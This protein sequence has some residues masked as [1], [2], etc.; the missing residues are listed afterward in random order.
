MN[1]RMTLLENNIARFNTS[2]SRTKTSCS[3][4]DKSKMISGAGAY[5][6]FGRKGEIDVHLPL[7][8]Q[9]S[10]VSQ[11]GKP[12]VDARAIWGT[13]FHELAHILYS[14]HSKN[15]LYGIVSKYDPMILEENRVEFLY[16][17]EFPG[18]EKWLEYG[19]LK[20]TN[21]FNIDSSM[22]HTN[23]LNAVLQA[24]MLF[25]ARTWIKDI[26]N[27]LRKNI[28][29]LWGSDNVERLDTLIL[30]FCSLKKSELGNAKCKKIMRDIEDL[31]PSNYY[32]SSYNPPCPLEH[33]YTSAPSSDYDDSSAVSIA[34]EKIDP[35]NAEDDNEET[36]DKQQSQDD[37]ERNDDSDSSLEDSQNSEK[38]NNENP[39]KKD[40]KSR[41]DKQ[42]SSE[43]NN[44][45]DKSGSEKSNDH[46]DD[47]SLGDDD[48]QSSDS[49]DEDS[50][51]NSFGNKDSSEN[52]EDNSDNRKEKDASSDGSEGNELDDSSESSDQDFEDGDA[53]EG[54]LGDDVEDGDD[55]KEKND[56]GGDSSDD[57]LSDSEDSEDGS[58]SHDG[59]AD[60]EY[61]ESS[62]ESH[63]EDDNG[64]SNGDSVDD[65]IN[66]ESND[67]SDGNSQ[68]NGSSNNQ[69]S[70]SNTIDSDEGDGTE[71]FI[72]TY[73]ESS[74]S[75]NPLGI[76][77][78]F[79]NKQQMDADIDV[80]HSD[81]SPSSGYY[82]DDIPNIYNVTVDQDI[83][84]KKRI[85]ERELERIN[86]EAQS[87]YLRGLPSGSVDMNVAFNPYRDIDRMFYEWTPG[88]EDAVS[89]E[90]VILVDCSGSMD[91]QTQQVMESVYPIIS[92][93]Y[94]FEG[95][96]H[97][98]VFAFNKS[99]HTIYNDKQTISPIQISYPQSV[100]G[101]D[102]IKALYQAEEIFRNSLIERKVLLVFTDG[103]WM[104]IPESYRK[105]LNTIKSYNVSTGCM[106][107]NDAQNNTYTMFDYH[108]ASND[109]DD[110]GKMANM[111]VMESMK[112]D[113]YM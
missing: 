98:N 53:V 12:S 9:N 26:H 102:P 104:G 33:D 43:K 66:N 62:D 11:T 105:I 16:F 50:E 23:D 18:T 90:L 83:T 32:D 94:D 110:F 30:E 57:G 65:D 55:D 109:I 4:L 39:R 92:A 44:K 51:N 6:A 45:K 37:D 10:Q 77:E 72:V 29:R 17:C 15:S 59:D 20:A 61:S 36:N 78:E 19:V 24:Y 74:Q 5:T 85:M 38:K 112:N 31:L 87:G 99:S 113:V 25:S 48:E 71:G 13:N 97:I 41:D 75:D 93:F 40:N 56:S 84:N 54:D 81:T 82:F 46:E 76:D 47:S 60:D 95:E 100:G 70:S 79:M 107:Y 96:S 111:I 42:G 28:V 8:L 52:N 7:L 14:E 88:V 101:T 27:N 89:T 2:I 22:Y 108:V 68:K 63:G 106:L 86:D 34:K 67:D 80:K 91:G 73:E 103:A 35:E 64:D 58:D 3:I 69:S 21:D 49:I 1:Y